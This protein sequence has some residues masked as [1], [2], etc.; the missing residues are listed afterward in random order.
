[1]SL[2]R[3]LITSLEMPQQAIVSS[4]VAEVVAASKSHALYMH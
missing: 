4:L 3:S 2:P 1:M